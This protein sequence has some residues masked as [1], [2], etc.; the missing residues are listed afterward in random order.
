MPEKWGRFMAKRI[1]RKAA[2][3][4]CHTSLRARNQSRAC[5]HHTAFGTEGEVFPQT[6]QAD[7]VPKNRGLV[8]RVTVPRS[9]GG[10]LRA[11]AFGQR[12]PHRPNGS[13]TSSLR[14]SRAVRIPH[15]ARATRASR[16][17]RAS[18]TCAPPASGS[19]NRAPSASK[20]RAVSAWR[21]AMGGRLLPAYYFNWPLSR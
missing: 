14:A 1:R 18:R 7:A 10:G 21:G 13:R 19:K 16:A 6:K 17:A 5:L 12:R 9:L 8:T 20:Q 2:W 11:A 3:V 4:E 15:V